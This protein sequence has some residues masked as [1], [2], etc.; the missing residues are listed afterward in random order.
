MKRVRL[1]ILWTIL[2]VL[3]VSIVVIVLFQKT[4]TTIPDRQGVVS[5][6][7]ETSAAARLGYVGW[8]ACGECHAQRVADFRETR[9]FR[10]CEIASE[11]PLSR[12]MADGPVQ[13]QPPDSDLRFDLFADGNQPMLTVTSPEG[14]ATSPIAYVYGAGAGTDEV[15]FTWHGDGLF[16]L[17]V[18]WLEPQKRWGVS[19]LDPDA[20][21][22]FSR[23]LTPQCLECHTLWVE[24]KTGTRNQYVR[25]EPFQLGVTC[26]RCHGPGHDHIGYH[27]QHPADKTAKA[28]VHPGKLSRDRQMDLCGQ[29]HSNAVRHRRPPYS[30][31][32]G[33]PLEDSFGVLMPERPEENRVA[34]QTRYLKE[35]RCYQQSEKMTCITCHDPH[36]A[37]R[38]TD[39]DAGSRSCVSCHQPEQCHAQSAL[40]EG[41]RNNCVGCHMPLRNK[42]QVHFETEDEFAAFPAPRYEHRIGIYPEATKQV[43]YEWYTKQQDA[44][45][46]QLRDNLGVE[47]NDWYH[48]AGVAARQESRFLL[49]IDS[50]RTALKYGESE[51]LR[52]LLTEAQ[53]ILKQMNTDWNEGQ[54]LKRDRRLDEAIALYE[55]QLVINPKLAKVQFELG[56][57]YAATGDKTRSIEYLHDS[58]RSDPEDP[59]PHAMLGWLDFLADRYA[60]SLAH[61]RN[62]T[63]LESWSDRIQF[64]QCLCLLK[65]NRW[66]EALGPLRQTLV[67]NP[68][69]REA[70]VVARKVLR[71]QFSTEQ[72]LAHAQNLVEATN[73]HQAE[74]ILTLAEIQHDA[75]QNDEA[76]RTLGIAKTLA[77]QQSA[78]IPQIQDLE[79]RLSRSKGF[80]GK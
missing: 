9:H 48:A 78:L 71:E 2:P 10:A 47:L 39:S 38:Q 64:Q 3:A 58:I 44:E 26:E 51:E 56:S 40:P 67:I 54:R 12:G 50:F 25:P 24:H 16:E 5:S 75:G 37:R 29:C 31:R 79:R 66:E 45:S 42:I 46:L 19:L 60:E 15:F 72:S 59:A 63:E 7:D 27:H 14:V 77:D 18:V 8:Q 69:H 33:E 6:S 11:I 34:N 23:P 73:W 43:L 61:Y 74:L 28:I 62:A 17:P 65:L 41:T 21:G 55:K 32:P 49:A 53:S 22:D 52:S 30:Y 80:K 1:S 70:I 35:S 76:R 20:G 68:A 13:F 36:H 4:S 57:M